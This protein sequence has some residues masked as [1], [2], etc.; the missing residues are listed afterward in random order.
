MKPKST[1]R[2]FLCIASSA[3]LAAPVVHAATFYWDNNGATAGFG[4][5]SGT[6]AQ[7]STTGGRWTTSDAGTLAGNL[8]QATSSSDVFNFG[9]GTIGL[10]AGTITVSGPVTMGNTT[11]GSASGAIVLTGGTINFSAAPTITVNNATNTIA[12]TIGGAATSLTKGGGGTLVLGGDNTYAGT[13]IVN[14]GTLAI[15]GAHSGT[16]AITLNGSTLDLGNST[17]TGALAS[18]VLTLNGGSFNYTRTGT[19]TQSFT[20]T[21]LNAGVNSIT[22]NLATQ[23][24]EL[25]TLVRGVGGTI[26]FKSASLGAITTSSANTNDILGGWATYDGNTWA[27]ANGAA[28]A[29]S[30]LATYTLS[31]VAGTTGA[32]YT[33][34]NIDVDSSVVIDSGITA[35]SLRFSAAAANALSLTAT[36][37]VTT[38]GILVGSGVGSNL[39]TI[40]GGTLAGAAGQELIVSQHNSSGGLTIASEIAN[41]GGATGL[42]KSGGGLLTLSGNNTFTG[43][44]LLNSG[45]VALG[46]AGAL[47]S[48]A[49][50][51]NA[52]TFTPGST[53]ILTLNGN[54]V[55]IRS[56]SGTGTVQN[57]NSTA[58]SLTIGNS[59][60]QASAYT[61]VIQDGSG[62][63]ALSLVK[64][65]TGI[66]SLGNA[67]T[68][69]GGTTLN[70]GTIDNVRADSLGTGTVT[71]AGDA[72]LKAFRSTADVMS[73]NIQINTGVTGQLNA[74]NQF[75]RFNI[76][77]VV[78]G[79]GTLWVTA[80]DNGNGLIYLN[81]TGNTHTGTVRIGFTGRSG[82]LFTSSIADGAGPIELG[83]TTGAGN[84]TFQGTNQN[85]VF[86]TRQVTLSGT[87]G[88]GSITN[89]SAN[90]VTISQ[91][92]AITGTGNKTLTLGGSN[93]NS[94]AF[95]G[96]IGDGA[97]SVISLSKTNGG[98]WVLSGA[99]SYTGATSI[100]G[101]T[102]SINS[103]ANLSSSSAIGAPTTEA[104]G[105]VVM[106][107][108][109]VTGTLLYTGAAAS[110]D[111]SIQINSTSSTTNTHTGGAT[112]T[113]NGS[114]ALTFTASTFNA[115]YTNTGTQIR[116]LTLNGTNG[117]TI[118]G[119]IQNN[120]E[121]AP[122]ALTKADDGTWT[123]G[124]ANTYTGNTVV[125]GGT[126]IV[127]GNQSLAT[128][129]VS[130]NGTSTL[131]GG[132]TLGGSVTV[133][134]AANVAP[135]ASVGTLS[136]GG[137]LT[138]SAM[139]GGD[140]KL[141]YQLGSLAS[142]D[143]I[144][145][146]GTLNIGTEVL[147]FGDFEFTNLTGLQNGTY[148]LIT[149]GVAVSGTLDPANL[150]GAVGTGTGTLQ[151]SGT[152][153]DIELVITGLGDGGDTA[154][155]TWAST[156][157]PNSGPNEDYDGDGVSNAVEFVLG[158][159]AATNDL[160][161]LPAVSASGGNM[162]FSFVRDQ[163][164]I[165][166]TTAVSIE[167]GTDLASWPDSYS[168]PHG[169]VA[170]I[171]GV[172]VVKN[173]PSG[174][175]TVTLT[176]PQSPDAKKFARLKVVISE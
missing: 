173:S 129:A 23:T 172:T 50:A 106:G 32:S 165:E 103:I 156:N 49:G 12:S 163:A 62:G 54:S 110:T 170:D 145:V 11:Y 89:N 64:S 118:A 154:Y 43:G 141:F 57:A 131:G 85:Q 61:G 20:T 150:T 78:S 38:G 96:N 58:G 155:G 153:T 8:T 161:K 140:G 16:G 81:N 128:G 6:W 42:T 113:N 4:T 97:G 149:S 15:G 99:N 9:T 121:T 130:V 92:L 139:A 91:D 119:I 175:D 31:S 143:K 136:I 116:T 122:V 134:A 100:T 67:N 52:V 137:D 45:E 109:N 17:A 18:T 159:S 75:F 167:V 84:L 56:L 105:T 94:N 115:N 176:V 53:G 69:T 162:T 35:S 93:T 74:I 72:E 120:S 90:I 19:N 21:N 44:L 41:N 55:V 47:N 65:G 82:S 30:G 77:G 152:G 124:G 10:G 34:G 73:N 151:I 102:L 114:G 126:L 60:N 63:G 14:A 80:T 104:N 147:G 171:P 79:E 26:D 95:S 125:N 83:V 117:G 33:D 112:I 25:G 146:T 36:N 135:G 29:I 27:V 71:F 133:A 157:A 86:T 37:T 22:T 98:T 68:Y 5:A 138:V 123:L 70:A 174:F 148:K 158:G 7:N 101:G 107:L 1:L 169:A 66:L 88:G 48:T 168:V 132:G 111:R 87:T 51:E 24:L 28:S 40:T 3:L 39:S 76:D 46:S 142:S 13:T 127:N 164:S 160:G 144:A 2:R 59:G 166:A 108:T